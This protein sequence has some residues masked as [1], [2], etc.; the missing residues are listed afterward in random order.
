MSEREKLLAFLFDRDDIRVSNVKFFRGNAEAL[1]VEQMCR[2]A[3]EV[4]AETFERWS[5]LEDAPPVA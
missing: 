4:I 3:G 1:T 5:D 2:V